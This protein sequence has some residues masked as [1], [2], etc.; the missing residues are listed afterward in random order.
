MGKEIVLEASFSELVRGNL[1]QI[2]DLYRVS[3][4]NDLK[5]LFY[6]CELFSR[7]G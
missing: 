6:G 2:N 7:A 3:P 1:L 4:R 5:L